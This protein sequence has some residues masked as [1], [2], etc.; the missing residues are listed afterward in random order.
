MD[1][2]VVKLST[3]FL[4]LMFFLGLV[5]LAITE[6]S[7]INS[8]WSSDSL[9]FDSNNVLLEPAKVCFGETVVFR[10]PDSIG[11]NFSAFDL[12]H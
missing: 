4:I 10:I 3:N 11:V 7:Y 8:V 2:A 6:F 1:D 12:Y 9:K 5:S